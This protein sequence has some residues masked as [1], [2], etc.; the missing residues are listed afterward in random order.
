MASRP[1]RFFFE[2]VVCVD[3]LSNTTRRMEA[4]A[5]VRHTTGRSLSCANSVLSG[6]L[7]CCMFFAVNI[8]THMFA[9]VQRREVGRT[10]AWRML[11]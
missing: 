3:A 4:L 6:G 11:E 1:M 8:G 9:G 5:E 10:I 7:A 2:W